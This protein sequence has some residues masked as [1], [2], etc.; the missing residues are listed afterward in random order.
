MKIKLRHFLFEKLEKVKDGN[1]RA[2]LYFCNAGSGPKQGEIRITYLMF[3]VALSLLLLLIYS[4]TLEASGWREKHV[5][6]EHEVN[7]AKPCCHIWP[8]WPP[9]RTGKTTCSVRRHYKYTKSMYIAK[10]LYVTN[11]RSAQR[12]IQCGYVTLRRS[13]D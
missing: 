6:A 5:S 7:H 10:I 9:S 2:T 12:I 13:Y 3:T 4:I 1:D 11:T 8:V